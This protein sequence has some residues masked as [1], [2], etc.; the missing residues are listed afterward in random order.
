M[1]TSK[2]ALPGAVRRQLDTLT[3]N[4][5]NEVRRTV[6][7]Q[8]GEGEPHEVEL[9]SSLPLQMSLYFNSFY[10]PFW[11]ISYVLMLQLKYQLLPE[12]YK[13][14]LVTLLIL[15][16]VIEVIRLYLGYSGNLQEKVPELAGFW[17]L[18]LL[19][20]LPLV[21]FLLC[22][23]GLMLLPLELA[24]HVILTAFLVCEIPLSFFTLRRSTRHLAG[25]F[26]QLGSSEVQA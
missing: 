22:D 1:A 7:D 10:F 20:Q 11:W 21:L 5:L 6:P 9:V 13:F 23:P 19:L 26:H 4:V 14:I 3:R 8:F 12:H 24:T 18:S 2:M 16:S 15:M 17:L 25:R